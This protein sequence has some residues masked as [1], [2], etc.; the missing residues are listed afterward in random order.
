MTIRRTL[1]I[2]YLLISLASAFLI[3]LMIFTHFRDV[4][5]QEIEFKLE[6]QA[7]TIMQQI[8]TTLFE[9]LENMASWS[10][11]DIM[12]EIRTRDV[13]KRLSQFL[14]N[15]QTEY[16]GVYQ[17]LF[18]TNQKNQIIAASQTGL[19][20]AQLPTSSPWLKAKLEQHLFSF[21]S[22][23]AFENLNISISIEDAFQLKPLGR[24][25]AGFNWQEI[26]RLLN[27][28]IPRKSQ[29]AIYYT[30]LVDSEGQVIATS[31]NLENKIPQFFVLQKSLLQQAESGVL[32]YYAP[33]LDQEVLAGYSRSTGYRKFN[34]LGWRIL[35]LQSSEFAFA[36]ILNIWH[37]LLLFVCLTL[38]LGSLVSLWMSA[39]ISKPIT[40][41]AKSTR[42]FMA[43]KPTQFKPIKASTEISELNTQFA[44][45]INSLEYSK[46]D[47]ARVAKLAIIGEMAASMAHEVRTPLGILR[48]SAQ[49]LQKEKQLSGIGLEMTEY[50]LS[51]TMRLNELVTTLLE[52]A[53]PRPPRFSLHNIQKIIEHT[54]ELLKTKAEAKHITLEL[55]P[56]N[57]ETRLYCD[58]DQL[59]QVFL[60]L[61]M[62]AI[63]HVQKQGH[64]ILSSQVEK[65]VLACTICDDGPGIPDTHKQTVFD[66]FYTQREEGIGLGL[67]VVQQI[68]LAHKG[69][70]FITDN[71]LGGTCFHIQLPISHRDQ[72]T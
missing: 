62:N 3:A 61:I 13:D 54:Q 45:M 40:L 28:S 6:S 18:V 42:D 26:I 67:T 35:I 56:N 41:L 70:V 60:N 14:H 57:S 59:I 53:S 21:D 17:Q 72:N 33:F 46:L 8:D 64:I 66:P 30:L 29:G 69:Q 25:Y 20:G 27:R 34:G 65:G 15:L 9:R 51:E 39:K 48:S 31:S 1:L 7:V 38:F 44:E 16:G 71:P 43:G 10:S 22:L 23:S 68:V 52:C 24:L 58:R 47:I 63:Q 55:K 11:L 36:P 4:L 32:N 2:S 37:V 5:R 49:I 12:Q 50:I 19:I